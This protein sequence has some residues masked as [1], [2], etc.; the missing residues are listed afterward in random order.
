LRARELAH[1]LYAGTHRSARRGAGVEFGGFREYTVGD[2]LRWLDRRSLLLYDR[3]I[4]RQFETET[5]RTVFLLVDATASMRY[6]GTRALASKYAYASALAAGVSKVAL[7][8]ADPVALSLLGPPPNRSHLLPRSGR[9]Q[10]ERIVTM[11]ESLDADVDALNDTSLFTREIEHVARTAKRGAIS[12]L[13]SDFLDV[14]DEQCRAVASLTG[15]R[16]SLIGIR[17]LDPDEVDFPFT[18]AARFVAIEGGH[19]IEAQGESVRDSYLRALEASELRLK[20]MFERCGARYARVLSNESPSSA[21]LRI[22]RP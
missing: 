14:S 19:H 5:D 12:L 7:G 15:S 18:D 4:V 21:L 8:A 13:F 22:L 1:G 6:R 20:A 17:V 3:T 9:L 10:F 2:D 16:R 11:L